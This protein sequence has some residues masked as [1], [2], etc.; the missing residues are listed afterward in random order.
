[1]PRGMG[2]QWVQASEIFDM[3]ACDTSANS[4]VFSSIY[5]SHGGRHDGHQPIWDLEVKVILNVSLWDQADLSDEF[6]L[7]RSRILFP[8]PG[9]ARYPY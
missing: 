8:S 6:Y 5:Q 3:S 1:M 2:S 9:Y 4:I 7:F